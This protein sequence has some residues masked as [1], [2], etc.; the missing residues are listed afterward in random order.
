MGDFIPVDGGDRGRGRERGGRGAPTG[1]APS[2][3]QCNGCA[4]RFDD[5]FD[6]FQMGTTWR[7]NHFDK[8]DVHKV[9]RE[10]LSRKRLTYDT[11]PSQ[12]SRT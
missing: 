1:C 3:G 7:A 8:D 10:T 6:G 2:M 9:N 12:N 4:G 11:D 5:D